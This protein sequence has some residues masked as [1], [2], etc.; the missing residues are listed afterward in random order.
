MARTRVHS[1]VPRNASVTDSDADYSTKHTR[2]PFVARTGIRLSLRLS[3]LVSADTRVARL[4]LGACGCVDTERRSGLQAALEGGMCARCVPLPTNALP[5]PT[6]RFQSPRVAQTQRS[7]T[8][9]HATRDRAGRCHHHA[10]GHLATNQGSRL[11]LYIA[12]SWPPRPLF[13]AQSVTQHR[14]GQLLRG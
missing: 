6:C 4:R 1:C 7:A 13:L 14:G 8:P 5:L 10:L 9:K 2:V 3:L 12:G 11:D